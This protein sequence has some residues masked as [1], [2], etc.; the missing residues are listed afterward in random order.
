M[1]YVLALSYTKNHLLANAA[2]ERATAA[3]A[4][5]AANRLTSRDSAMTRRHSDA[6]ENPAVASSCGE[7]GFHSGNER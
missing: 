2:V 3:L 7:V 6:P 5:A 1:G 4:K